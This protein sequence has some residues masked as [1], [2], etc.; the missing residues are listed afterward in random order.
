MPT[1]GGN[2]VIHV[3]LFVAIQE[4]MEYKMNKITKGEDMLSSLFLGGWGGDI[5]FSLHK[6][7][8][9][10]VDENNCAPQNMRVMRSSLCLF[11]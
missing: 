4:K 3:P 6:L 1:P 9:D 2:T 10:A 11:F 8:K 7:L 5:L